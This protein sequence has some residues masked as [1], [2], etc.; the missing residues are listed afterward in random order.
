MCLCV[1]CAMPCNVCAHLAVVLCFV[2]FFSLLLPVQILEKIAQ[3]PIERRRIEKKRRRC[4]EGQDDEVKKAHIGQIH[5]LKHIHTHMYMNYYHTTAT[6]LEKSNHKWQITTAAAECQAAKMKYIQYTHN[7]QLNK[8]EIIIIIIVV[9]RIV[10]V[11]V[12]SV[13]LRA[14]SCVYVYV[15]AIHWK[16]HIFR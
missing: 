2:V 10:V 16:P 14:R 12:F 4:E 9:I 1:C 11:W 7:I 8:I 6:R 13:R 15:R 3:Q 5:T